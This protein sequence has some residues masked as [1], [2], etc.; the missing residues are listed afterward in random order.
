[1]NSSPRVRTSFA[2]Y[3]PVLNG[4]ELLWPF[5][6]GR[7]QR[8]A[9]AVVVLSLYD[10]VQ[11]EPYYLLEWKGEATRLRHGLPLTAA[12]YRTEEDLSNPS[13]A[14]NLLWLSELVEELLLQR[15][16]L[17]PIQCQAELFQLYGIRFTREAFHHFCSR[18]RNSGVHVHWDDVSKNE[19]D[20]SITSFGHE[21]LTNLH[22]THEVIRLLRLIECPDGFP[23]PPLK[24]EALESYTMTLEDC[25]GRNALVGENGLRVRRNF[26]ACIARGTLL[27]LYCGTACLYTEEVPAHKGCTMSLFDGSIVVD[28]LAYDHGV[29]LFNANDVSKN[30]ASKRA[31]YAA[32]PVNTVFVTAELNG[33]EYVFVLVIKDI[34]PGDEIAMDYGN[35]FRM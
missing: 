16:P 7:K 3:V 12:F 29:L 9:T 34:H 28:P 1:M 18:R 22:I 8:R 26:N 6:A 11:G 23:E 33:W 24:H 35:S 10:P 30:L 27:G 4:R 19:G 17:P 5:L 2:P 32:L 13:I 15:G 14:Q 25:S 20:C 31:R 21:M